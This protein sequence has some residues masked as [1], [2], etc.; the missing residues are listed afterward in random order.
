[1]KRR[2]YI[3]GECG[4][5]IVRVG[6]GP[7]SPFIDLFVPARLQL[8]P[9]PEQDRSA[10]ALARLRLTSLRLLRRIAWRVFVFCQARLGG[11]R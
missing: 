1:M 11:R 8:G 7:S 3:I 10:A 2:T 5:E 9:D 6:A 4:P